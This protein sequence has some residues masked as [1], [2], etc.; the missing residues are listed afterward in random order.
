M[1][2]V[3]YQGDGVKHWTE[4]PDPKLIDDTDAIVQIDAVTICGTDLHILKGDVPEVTPGRIL[5]HE[6]T[7][8]V[9]ETGLA[10]RNFRQGDRVL[11]S[12]ISSCG[13]CTQCRKGRYGQ[14][15]QGGG[16]LFGHTIDGVQAEYARVPFADFS[17]YRIP[18]GVTDEQVLYLSDVLPTGY[19]V[20]VL[21]GNVR[22]ADVV[23]I[24]GAGPIGL[25]AIL[26][27]RLFSA[28]Q[29]VSIDPL[30]SRRTFALEFGADVAVS[31]E[32]AAEAI[33]SLNNGN[34]AD[35]VIE[36]VGKPDTFELCT[37]LVRPG[38]RVANAGVHGK[39]AQL[40]LE[41]LW[42]EDV[43]LTTGLVDTTS[44][45]ELMRLVEWGKIDATKFTTHRF[46][47]GQ[48]MA[49]YDFFADADRYNTLKVLM[50]RD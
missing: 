34:G 33:A 11:L 4:V 10:V 20:G 49:A 38:G 7:G 37:E 28:G 46:A 13:Q 25:S 5:G 36:A 47:L 27:S 9:I 42:I 18:E 22:P 41:K 2:A 1:Q 23:A 45:P 8:T 24:V 12:C 16:W 19:E 3:V 26:G 30:A 40:H 17:C 43:T 14:C 48:A 35:V 6:A 29:I 15:V 21:N 50:Q 31:P 39:P 44:I 32:D